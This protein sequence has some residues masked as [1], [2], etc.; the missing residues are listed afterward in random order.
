M[1]IRFLALAALLVVI[2]PA[3]I[4]AAKFGILAGLVIAMA[5]ANGIMQPTGSVLGNN[6][7][8][9]LSAGVILTKALSLVFTKRPILKRIS[10]DL[11]DA[12][13]KKGD[14]I[15]SR[16]FA[17]PPVSDFGSGAADRS[18]V[19]VPVTISGFKQ[20]KVSFT[21][22]ELTS[23]DR[24][25]IQ[26]SAEPIAVGIANHIVDSVAALWTPTNFPGNSTIVP[27]ADTGYTTLTT[28]RGAL[29]GRGAPDDRFCVVNTP[30]YTN[31]LDD[32][33]CNRV[34][35]VTETDGDPISTGQLGDV[36]GFK[37]IMEYP[38]LPTAN[39][40]IG[41]AGAMDSTVFAM[42]VPR[43]PREVLPN[44]PVGGS[45]GI[46]TE[47]ITGMS[48]M[49]VEWVDIGTLSANVM[50]VWLE[51]Y[52]VGNPATGQLLVSA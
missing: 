48:I 34:Q 45:I 22:A 41:F 9:T 23:T 47:P 36:A 16:I 33:L 43:D 50:L 19:D 2:V 12:R 25:L 51:G 42:R 29:T 40:L 32:P 5:M 27:V 44:V 18:D 35:K 24:D 14:T 15:K 26:E 21:A 13:A 39:N 17:V 38:A 11:S 4:V 37:S 10:R 31:L 52:A 1:K 6:S 20:I 28:L 3:S 30:V 8:G 49:A 46:V 7:L